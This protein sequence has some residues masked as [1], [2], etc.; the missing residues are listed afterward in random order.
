MDVVEIPFDFKEVI[1]IEFEKSPAGWIL[2]LILTPCRVSLF[3]N[4]YL[5]L[6]ALMCML[7][8]YVVDGFILWL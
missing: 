6:S 5:C 4:H 2:E 1:T 3:V 7:E 8:V